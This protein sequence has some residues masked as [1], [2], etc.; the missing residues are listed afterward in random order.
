MPSVFEGEQRPAGLEQSMQ[1]R[2]PLDMGSDRRQ[3]PTLWRHLQDI[4]LNTLIFAL[5]ILGGREVT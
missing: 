1:K 5:I 4:V 2:Q 3:M